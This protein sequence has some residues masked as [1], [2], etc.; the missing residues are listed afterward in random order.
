VFDRRR[1]NLYNRTPGW[2][3]GSLACTQ[4]AGNAEFITRLPA[5]ASICHGVTDLGLECTPCQHSGREKPPA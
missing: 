3:G 5:L 1:L 2:L 4:Q